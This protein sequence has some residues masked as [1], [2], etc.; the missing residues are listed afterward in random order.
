[1]SLK[2]DKR[3]DR[4][5][6][7]MKKR[8]DRSIKMQPEYHLIVTEGTATEPQYFSA[9]R[10]VIN[11]KYRGRIQ[12]DIHGE[13]KNTVSLFEMAKR[14]LQQSAIVYKHIWIVYDTDDFPQDAINKTAELCAQS[15]N[16]ETKYHAIWSNQCIELWFLLHFCYLQTDMH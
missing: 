15:S 13:G 3:S 11:R 5:K 14:Y 10:D 8:R 9:I 7:W 4:D 16:E 12:L 2:P 6:E 1:M